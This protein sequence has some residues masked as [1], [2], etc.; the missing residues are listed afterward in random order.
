MP[1]GDGFAQGGTAVDPT[2]NHFTGKERDGETGNDYFGARYYNSAT[3]RFLSPDWSA[4]E[5][6]VPYAKLDNPQSLNLYSYVYNN[7]L[8]KVDPDGHCPEC[9]FEWGTQL[10]EEGESN[11]NV[12]R[13]INAAGGIITAGLAV[14]GGAASKAVDAVKSVDW[15]NFN[16]SST[17]PIPTSAGDPRNPPNAASP[18]SGGTVPPEDRDPKR[19][20]T[21]KESEQ[22]KQQAKGKCTTCGEETTEATPYTKGSKHPG[23]E[24]QAG[25]KKAWSKGGRTTLENGK[26]QCRSCNLKERENSK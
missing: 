2:E 17:D 3:G 4:K 8:G 23:S 21:P 9:V 20:F 25:H 16:Y 14:A 24:G 1:F 13:A 12:Q 11:P 6:P 5:E 22:L 7:P 10:L 15:N 26:H 19:R 18:N